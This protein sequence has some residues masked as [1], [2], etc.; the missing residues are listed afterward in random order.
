MNQPTWQSGVRQAGQHL[1]SA[2]RVDGAIPGRLD[3]Q[4]QSRAKWTCLTGN[5][6][7]SLL[8]LRLFQLT[9]TAAYLSAAQKLNTFL[10]STQD[11]ET[12]N[13]NIRGAIKGSDP[14]NGLYAPYQYLNW[15]TKFYID[16]LLL[17]EEIENH[18]AR[19]MAPMASTPV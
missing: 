12:K 9:G 1:I 5:A 4:W 16:A 7:I 17:Q 8:W 11:I 3:S 14:I 18:P 6:Q 19:E 10:Q 15:A 2:Q 13:A